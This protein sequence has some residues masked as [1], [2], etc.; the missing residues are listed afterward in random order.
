MMMTDGPG[1]LVVKATAPS[2]LHLSQSFLQGTVL[3]QETI[4]LASVIGVSTMKVFVEI[5]RVATDQFQLAA[6]QIAR[7]VPVQLMMEY[8][9]FVRIVD[10]PVGQ[11]TAALTGRGVG[12]PSRET[13][14]VSMLL[15]VA[16]HGEH[17]R[18]R[19]IPFGVDQFQF[20]VLNGCHITRR[21]IGGRKEIDEIRIVAARRNGRRHFVHFED[22]PRLFR[23]RRFRIEFDF[24][25][26]H[27][28]LSVSVCDRLHHF[29]ILSAWSLDVVKKRRR[30]Q[31]GRL[32]V[33]QP[34]LVLEYSR[35]DF[36]VVRCCC[37]A[38]QAVGRSLERRR[39][40]MILVSFRARRRAPDERI[41]LIQFIEHAIAGMAIHVG[42]NSQDGRR[43]SV[44]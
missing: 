34:L 22:G 37:A 14:L 1:G 16:G 43:P 36:D 24:V 31:S 4:E 11:T 23:R 40:I 33:D 38:V 32:V 6:I 29:R 8:R 10:F 17:G 9:R 39:S 26:V 41:G 25:L 3:E 13:G 35:L 21:V 5:F 12:C 30:D 15:D 2:V 42:C 28:N 7:I 27:G 18:R 44:T 19:P 20:F